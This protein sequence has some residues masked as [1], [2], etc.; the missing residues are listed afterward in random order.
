MAS[1][2]TIKG[3]PAG[4]QGGGGGF[5]YVFL[6]MVLMIGVGTVLS[7]GFVPLDPNGPE[8]P[9]TLEPYFDQSDYGQQNVIL[10]TGPTLA[11][12]DKSLQLKTFK[13]NTCGQKTVVEFV[14][15]TS[16][17]MKFDNKMSKT[18]EALKTFTSKLPGKAGIGMVS[19]SDE[20]KEEIPLDFYKEV[21][22]DTAEAIEGLDSDG[23]TRTRDGLAKAMTSIQAAKVS[24][25]FP[26]DYKYVLILMTDGVPEVPPSQPRTC[27]VETDD[28]NTAPAKR[29][30][31]KDQDPLVAPNI[32]QQLK[33]SGVEI[34][35]INIYSPSYA[36]DKVMY[37]YLK[38][39][40]Q[41]VISPPLD[42]HYFETIS[43]DNLQKVLDNVINNACEEN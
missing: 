27:Y 22:E 25:K 10:P 23:W 38:K 2:G 35:A 24:A 6:I 32:A 30:F 16:G 36:S 18:K 8:G 12:N 34:Y 13:V 20:V 33:N 19:F 40:L 4:Q 26:N 1:K 39:L 37:P 3:R 31:A 11:G 29:C 7:G 17:S 28:P 42:T 41:D 9:P 43:A 15:D 14:V 21:K 5:L